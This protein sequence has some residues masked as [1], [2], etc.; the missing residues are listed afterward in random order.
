MTEI[1]GELARVSVAFEQPTLSLLHQRNAA[2]TVA[3]FRVCF[4]AEAPALPTNRVHAMVQA[5]L[6]DLRAQGI[7]VLPNTTGRD[8]CQRWRQ[9]DWL[10][11]TTGDDGGEMYELTSAAQDALKVVASLTRERAALSEHRVATIVDAA[12]KFNAEANPSRAARADILNDQIAELTRERDR[13]LAGGDMAPVTPEFMLDGYLD[14][15]NLV[16]A[17]PGDFARVQESFTRV[18]ADILAAFREEDSHAGQ[19]V[20]VYLRRV[21]ALTT[22]T[23]EGRAF[24]GAF[25]LLRD[26]ALLAQLREDL[27]ALL[28]HPLAPEI[29]NDADRRELRGTVAMIRRGLDAV[30]GQRTRVARTLREHIQTHNA[31]HDRE[32][33]ATLRQ[34][35]VELATWMA[36]SGRRARVPMSLLP[37]QV[38]VEHLR[39]RLHDP[40]EDT[41]PPPL[42]DVSDERPEELS[43]EELRAQ[44]GPSVQA[45]RALLGAELPDTEGAHEVFNAADPA[46]RRPVEVLGLLHLA[47]NGEMV[48]VG[49]GVEHYQA[50]RTD[51]TTRTL[52]AA[53]LVAAPPHDGLDEED[54]T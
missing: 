40:G 46:M 18:R 49:D 17:L 21:D 45:W 2:V 39:T 30:I 35:E 53:H 20:D 7:D 27:T 26:D 47:T 8:L 3:M 4:S 9:R 38:E 34:L 6:D 25:A 1:A 50:V 51:G 36:T 24:Q 11:R 48:Q 10:K 23:P 28:D 31:A 29:L 22:Q 43:V 16:S 42:R 41:P 14:L 44:G 32:L 33:D 15:L 52:A 54:P 13:L 12:R 37:E 5:N 19:V